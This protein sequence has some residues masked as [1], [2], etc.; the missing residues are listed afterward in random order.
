VKSETLIEENKKQNEKIQ[1]KSIQIEEL[2]KEL[3][4]QRN[5]AIA[6]A[7]ESANKLNESQQEVVK[8]QKENSKLKL[9]IRQQTEIK[10]FRD[11]LVDIAQQLTS[12]EWKSMSNRFNI[13]REKQPDS[14]FNFF[15]WL[16]ETTQISSV[17]LRLL[18]DTL[19]KHQKHLLVKQLIEPYREMNTNK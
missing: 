7:E 16:V 6:S 10:N 4:K 12:E 13:P 17:D 15:W 18:E 11:L 19:I 5:E 8:L 2:S 9:E 1:Q 3:K 14:A